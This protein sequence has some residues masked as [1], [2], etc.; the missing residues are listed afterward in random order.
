MSDWA[1]YLIFSLAKNWLW[2]STI[3]LRLCMA[4]CMIDATTNLDCVH[5]DKLLCVIQPLHF[6]LLLADWADTL[7]HDWVVWNWNPL[8]LWFL[9]CGLGLLAGAWDCIA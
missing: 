5:P 1:T 4:A 2:I 8:Q 7:G 9:S 6:E 3:F